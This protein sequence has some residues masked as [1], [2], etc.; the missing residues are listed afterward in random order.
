M[1]EPKSRID[2]E[3]LDD[4]L[5]GVNDEHDLTGVLRQLSKQLIERALEAE[6]TEH[7]GHDKGEVV[8]NP[9]GNVRNGSS[10]KTLKGEL[11][12]AAPLGAGLVTP[13]LR[14]RSTCP[15]TA[16]RASSRSWSR[17][18]NAVWRGWMSASCRFTRVA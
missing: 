1:A 4:L 15:A 14:W 13:M 11:G 17:S 16:R 10:K 2:P 8:I 5:R 3:V 6:L 9:E 18:I 12:I 7:L